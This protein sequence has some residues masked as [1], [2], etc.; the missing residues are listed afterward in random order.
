MDS[1]KS[2]REFSYA[3]SGVD[4]KKASSLIG[5][6]KNKIKNTHN[7]SVNGRPSGEFGSFAGLFQPDNEF[8]SSR[9][10]IA[11]ATD[12]VGTKIQLIRKY[13]Y[14]EGVGFDLVAMSV[15]DLICNG[16][17]P[18]FFLDYISCGKLSDSW[19][20]PVMN[21]IADAC[22]AAKTPL[23]GGESAEHPGVMEEDDFDLAGFC[24][25]F[26]KEENVLPKKDQIQERDVILGIPSSGLHSNGF[27]LVRKILNYIEKENI[28]THKNKILDED[29][30]KKNILTPT[31]LYTEIYPAID[32]GIVKALVHIT[33]GGFYEN[34]PRVLPDNMVAY[35][36]FKNVIEP[37][38]YQV[39]RDYVEMKELYSTF[40][41][42]IG[43]AVVL[44]ERY[45]DDI[46]K[47]YKDAVVIGNI[48]QKKSLKENNVIIA[49]LDHSFQE[50]K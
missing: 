29:W 47:I 2:S 8:Y 6:L 49:G 1:E 32:S 33:G 28:D 4:T 7:F 39:L 20:I 27:S 3:H 34:I 9:A 35:F 45:I 38:V 10:S 17:R 40:N 21:S 14:Y 22:I 46:Q 5:A 19:Y 30:V 13:R 11:A 15:N 43:L 37:E 26:L 16:A 48:Q 24:V 23:L 42:G 25:G 12:G 41:M 31:R 18:A 36:D 44:D 50:S